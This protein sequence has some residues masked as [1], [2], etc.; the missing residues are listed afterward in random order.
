MPS[1]RHHQN[2]DRPTGAHRKWA[3]AIG[4][5][6]YKPAAAGVSESAE[7]G[8]GDMADPAAVSQDPGDRKPGVAIFGR[9][10]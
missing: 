9:A 2:V 4:S 5:G 3:A 1:V 6:N 7:K 8:A 10:G